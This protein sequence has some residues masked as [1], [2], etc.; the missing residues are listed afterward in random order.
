ML[1]IRSIFVVAP[2]AITSVMGLA[3]PIRLRLR[4]ASHHQLRAIP[5]PK[6][7]MIQLAERDIPV[8]EPLRKRQTTNVVPEENP[9]QSNGG[10]IQPY[11]NP[12]NPA[13]RDVINVK[14]DVNT[15]STNLAARSDGGAIVDFRKRQ[16]TNVVPEENPTQSNGGAIQP[17][18]NPENPAKRDLIHARREVNTFSTNL[19]ARSDGGAVVDFRKRQTTNVVPEEN[20]TQSNGGAIQPY[21]NPENPAKRDLINVKRDVNTFSTSLAAR[22]DGGAIVEF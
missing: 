7:E 8:A 10:A 9:T 22:S 15:F 13:K 21:S 17:Y 19:A 16:T 6:A 3:V 2:L 4:S 12:E 20:P 14:R 1:F 5:S 18:S 11:S